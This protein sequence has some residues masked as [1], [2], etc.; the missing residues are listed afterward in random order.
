VNYPA[1]RNFSVPFISSFAHKPIL[2]AALGKALT[3]NRRW[4]HGDGLFHGPGDLQAAAHSHRIIRSAWAGSENQKAGSIQCLFLEF[5][6]S[7]NPYLISAAAGAGYHF[8]S[9]QCDD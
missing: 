6:I 1:I 8:W 2:R 7:R 5:L 4:L 3:V 9:L